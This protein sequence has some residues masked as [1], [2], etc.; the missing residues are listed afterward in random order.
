MIN[1]KVSRPINNLINQSVSFERY[2][3]FNQFFV[4]VILFARNIYDCFTTVSII[5]LIGSIDCVF[6]KAVHMY[7]KTYL[8]SY[9]I[10]LVKLKTLI[11]RVYC[12]AQKSKSLSITS[13]AEAKRTMGAVSV[14]LASALVS[15]IIQC[16]DCLFQSL[17]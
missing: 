5:L 15:E 2:A 14:P 4:F 12:A 7:C 3:F 16:L 13:I 17:E 1:I 10:F 6:L 8:L 11:G 9:G